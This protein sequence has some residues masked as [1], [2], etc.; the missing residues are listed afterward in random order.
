MPTNHNLSAK[1]RLDKAII[2]IH[3]AYRQISELCLERPSFYEPRKDDGLE[4]AMA[5]LTEADFALIAWGVKY[6]KAQVQA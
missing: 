1:Q 6:E 2:A 3:E 5:H 4:V